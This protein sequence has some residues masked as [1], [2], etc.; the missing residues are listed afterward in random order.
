[1]GNSSCLRKCKLIADRTLRI[2]KKACIQFSIVRASQ[3]FKSL[4]RVLYTCTKNEHVP[5]TSGHLITRSNR[6][7]GMQPIRKVFFQYY[8]L[9]ASFNFRTKINRRVFTP[10]ISGC[11]T[12]FNQ[13]KIQ[14]REK[15]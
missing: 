5:L 12:M 4:D 13:Q 9:M 11:Q 2:S 15:L 10:Q 1:M 8:I 3:N 6:L 14:L 7:R